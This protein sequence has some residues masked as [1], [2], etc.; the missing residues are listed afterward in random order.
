MKLRDTD[1]DNEIDTD[2][3]YGLSHFVS[4]SDSSDLDIC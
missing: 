3:S 1:S 2:S 4:E